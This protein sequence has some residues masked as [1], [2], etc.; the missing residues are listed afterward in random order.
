MGVA[1]NMGCNTGV[2]NIAIMTKMPSPL[3]TSAANNGLDNLSSLQSG[4]KPDWPDHVA[5]LAP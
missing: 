1:K 2:V 4:Y 3:Y 5:T